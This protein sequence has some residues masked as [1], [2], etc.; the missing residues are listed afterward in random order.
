MIDE[1]LRRSEMT[2][3]DIDIFGCAAGPGSFTGLRIGIGI[4]KAF[5]QSSGKKCVAVNTLDAL[6]QN[7]EGDNRT[8]CAII[9]ARRTDV[10]SATYNDSKRISQYR[11]MQI[12]ELLEELKGQ[13]V[14]FVGDGSI[15][16]KEEI[17]SAGLSTANGITALQHAGS[18]GILTYRKAADAV[19]A[20][21]LE[22]F[23]LRKTQA[24]RVYEQKH[25][26]EK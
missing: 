21:E 11:A 19:S 7:L 5:C 2:L 17:E 4:I 12:D 14:I 1:C 10:Y 18:V 25:R 9:D 16:F 8:V 24:E 26:G 22:P 15:R 20:Y 23:Y 6:A 13:E 3:E